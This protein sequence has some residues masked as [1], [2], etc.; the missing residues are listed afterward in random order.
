MWPW[1]DVCDH[2]AVETTI[3][4]IMEQWARVDVLVANAGDGRDRP[5]DTKASAIDPVLLESFQHCL[6]AMRWLR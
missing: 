2:Q 5:V 1:L 3:A 4:Q 6:L